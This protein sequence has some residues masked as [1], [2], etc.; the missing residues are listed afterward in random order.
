MP[1]QSRIDARGALHHV[2]IRGIDRAVIFRNDEDRESFLG[3]L[4]GILM[5][6][7]TPCYAWSLLSNH[8]HFLF[9]SGI[10]GGRI[11]SRC[12][13]L[14]GAEATASPLALADDFFV[15]PSR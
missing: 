8:A 10:S 2:M 3:R 5:G 14:E 6:S 13:R 15:K 12:G 9:R 4:G 7:S 11:A 1:R